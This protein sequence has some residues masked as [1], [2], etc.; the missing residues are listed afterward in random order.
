MF[1]RRH[2][3]PPAALVYGHL[4]HGFSWLLLLWGAWTASAQHGYVGFAWIHTVALAWVTMAA[5]AVLLHAMPNFVDVEWRGET[6]ARWSLVAFAAGAALL[7]YGFLANARII[8][9]G[10]DLLLAAIVVYLATAFWTL[11]QAM[12]GERVQRAVARAFS[13][14]LLFLLATA[15]V[16]YGLAGLLAGRGM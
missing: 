2:W 3:I 11:S 15:V 4:A 5:F 8:G 16:G 9:V 1:A 7:I 13:G 12:N 10:G 6:V 14:T